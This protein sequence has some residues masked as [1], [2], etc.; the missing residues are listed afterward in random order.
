MRKLSQDGQLMLG[1]PRCPLHLRFLRTSK[2]ANL[3]PPRLE[4]LAANLRN[5]KHQVAKRLSV[6]FGAASCQAKKIAALQCRGS[7]S[8]GVW[9][10]ASTEL[11][12]VWA[13]FRSA[14]AS[15]VL[16]GRS[17]SIAILTPADLLDLRLS[18]LACARVRWDA[19][20]YWIM[21]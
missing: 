2:A 17:S 12:S 4:H 6:A 8:G 16:L 19:L 18:C 11:R 5:L 10:R 7:R 9:R 3:A 1:P 15:P 21:S 14:K 13:R 20:R